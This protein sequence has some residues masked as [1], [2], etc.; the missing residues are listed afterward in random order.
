MARGGAR[1][2]RP[3]EVIPLDA[4]RAG[5]PSSEAAD[6]DR[7]PPR[8]VQL[9]YPLL[10][11]VL[12][13][14]GA[15]VVLPLLYYVAGFR[16]SVIDLIQ[17][18]TGRSVTI[19]DARLD[20]RS[21]VGFLFDG[22]RVRE[23]ASD[24]VALQAD[25]VVVNVGL[26]ALLHRQVDVTAVRL[27][28]PEVTIVRAEDGSYDLADLLPPL[29][30]PA[31]APGS[32][33]E[34]WIRR[35][36]GAL[37]RSSLGTEVLVTGGRVIVDDRR[38]GSRT[39]L[40]AIDLALSRAVLTDRVDFTLSTRFVRGAD[41]GSLRLNGAVGP[42]GRD[43]PVPDLTAELRVED[44]DLGALA[45][46]WLPESATLRG[47]GGA[48]IQFTLPDGGTLSAEGVLRVVEPYYADPTVYQKA[49]GGH[50][51]KVS[52]S[53]DVTDTDLTIHQHEITL[54][55]VSTTG[56]LVVRG[57]DGDDPYVELLAKSP[58]LPLEDAAKFIPA[59]FIDRPLWYFLTSRVR[60]GRGRIA[61]A[62]I[63]GRL[64]Q[65]RAFSEPE[66]AD[67]VEARLEFRGGRLTLPEG[68]HDATDVDGVIN[69]SKG[70]LTF[71]DWTGLYGPH[72][73]TRAGG[74]ID[75]IYA[76]TSVLDFEVTGDVDFADAVAQLS[77][78]YFPEPV[79][80]AAKRVRDPKGRAEL[81]VRPYSAFTTE[82]F[83]LDISGK[84]RFEGL[85]LRLEGY[86]WSIEGLGGS[87]YFDEREVGSKGLGA[88]VG[89]DRV[90]L[91][92]F[93]RDYT[94]SNP[95]AELNA[96]TALIDVS[97]LVAL[98]PPDAG[99]KAHGIASGTFHARLGG[100]RAPRL[101]AVA[102]L[103]DVR[104]TAPALF[105]SFGAMTGD[106]TYSPEGEISVRDLHTTF[107]GHPA[108]F[109]GTIDGI[110][111]IR[112][113]LS[114]RAPSLD[115]DR[116]FERFWPDLP[117]G[118]GESARP[119]A[120]SPPTEED[121]ARLKSMELRGYLESDAMRM[122]RVEFHNFSSSFLV[123][124]GDLRIEDF[125][126][127]S[128]EGRFSGKGQFEDFFQERSRV[129]DLRAQCEGLDVGELSQAVGIDNDVVTG[130]I[131]TVAR[132]RGKAGDWSAF[133]ESVDG[134]VS[135]SMSGGEIHGLPVLSRLLDLLGFNL[136]GFSTKQME[137]ESIDADFR[138]EHG[139]GRT[140]NFFID[141]K[142]MKV[143]AA[144]EV[145]LPSE[146]MDMVVEV[147]P[148]ERFDRIV[149]GIPI[150]GTILTGPDRN[151][152]V[153]AVYYRIE[154]PWD[155]PKVDQTSIESLATLWRPA[156]DWL[157]KLLG[158][159][160]GG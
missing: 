4:S 154:G 144:G 146:T 140:D 160:G 30:K 83:D 126:F 46:P 33:E 110:D 13:A 29:E 79:R 86:P 94:K 124:A 96:R 47:R 34:G 159:D 72:R 141:S 157:Y 81:S 44:V 17:T 98:A 80:A 37:R 21:G 138:F 68:F 107:V 122:G 38:D 56:S 77:L 84:T 9:F 20:F 23:R 108:V 36:V 89:G 153:L 109:N 31:P 76:P 5:A 139:R 2:K 118:T 60:G 147:Q 100:G 156:G 136:K 12:F 105:E 92:G 149:G 106:V 142:T 55:R 125:K 91:D 73:I 85:A 71:T 158:R 22:V 95:V 99:V 35:F 112:A 111:P 41:L 135:F 143:R 62:A 103:K 40:E 121:A 120:P 48:L 42:F 70:D 19:D 14:L 74:R 101:S 117:P 88:S 97:K 104:L 93:V 87:A 131:S 134:A 128:L 113:S 119:K 145:L 58:L 43:A 152:K 28:R 25:E 130:K 129:L 53:G 75:K 69:W 26:R 8:R 1:K 15:A 11:V 59:P 78:D 27:T 61:R 150:V 67:V 137:Y 16:T 123:E 82:N 10:F 45:K 132:L 63:R 7:P 155:D 133:K 116:L 51:L 24:R 50:E 39:S 52:F 57:L 90:S 66:N 3:A 65:L 32:E 151:R 148:L 49:L 6:G 127:D 102:H 54:D 18:K 115:L 114:V 64:S